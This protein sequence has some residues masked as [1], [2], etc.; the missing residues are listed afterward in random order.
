MAYTAKYSIILWA[1][2]AILV[3]TNVATTVLNYHNRSKLRTTLH[4][5]SAFLNPAPL[6]SR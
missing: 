5:Y 6:Q 4:S 3:L 2:G 1:L